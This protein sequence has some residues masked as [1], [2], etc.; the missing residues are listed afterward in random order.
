V[1]RR[2][3]I[4][5]ADGDSGEAE[6]AAFGDVPGDFGGGGGVVDPIGADVGD[7]VAFGVGAARA[8]SPGDVGAERVG[9]TEAGTLA[10]EYDGGVGVESCADLVT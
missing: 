3:G 1:N 5:L 4:A 7:A 6:A 9:R 10:D 8:R 2:G